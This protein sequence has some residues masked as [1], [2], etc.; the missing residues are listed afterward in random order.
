MIRTIAALAAATA[1][2]PAPA[3]APTRDEALTCWLMTHPNRAPLPVTHWPA[4][5]PRGERIA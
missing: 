4:I 1:L 3:S 5:A 2:A